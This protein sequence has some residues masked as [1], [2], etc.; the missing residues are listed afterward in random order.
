MIENKKYLFARDKKGY[1]ADNA[2]KIVFLLVVCL[3]FSFTG[4]EN[5]TIFEKIYLHLDRHYYLS[6]D[7]VWF[8]AYLVDAQT[9]KLSSKSSRIL[10]AEL[11][12]PESK[13]LMRR[14][15]FVDTDGC[16]I[17]DFK[18]KDN[19]I[20]GKYR[21]RAYTKWMLNFGDVFVFEKE[22]EVQNISEESTSTSK[23]EIKKKQKDN[24]NEKTITREDVEIEFFPESGSL[25]SEIANIV[26]F[27]ATDWSGKG[28]EVSGG[29]LNSNGDTVVLFASEYLGMGKF[30]FVPQ[31]GETYQAF[32]APKGVQYSQ[33]AKLPETLNKGFVMNISDVDTVF[34]LNIRTNQ[35]IF[36]EFSGK[37]MFLTFRQSEK[38]LFGHEIALNTR[39]K[40]VS[41]SKSLL[42]S[43]ITR[44]TLY[45]EHEKPHCERLVYIENKEKVNI[46][47]TPKDDT[48]SIIKVTDGNGQSVK[49][50]LSMSITNSIVPD[51]TFDIE[52]YLRLESEIKGKIER[53]TAY[54]DSANIDR[55]RQIDLL[56]LT[57]GWRDFVWK[58][59]ENNIPEFVGYEMEQGLKITGHVE[60]LVGSKPYPDATVALL[61]PDSDA[62]ISTYIPNLVQKKGR[63]FTR[64]DSLGNYG[65]GYMNFLGYRTLLLT[66]RTEKD[67]AAGEISINPLFMPAEE[68]PVKI[69]KQYQIDSTYRFVA[70]NY[71]KKDYKLTDTIVLDPVTI[72]DRKDGHLI[73]DREITP[74][75]DSLWMSLDFYI[76][77]QAS[78]LVTSHVESQILNS[79]KITFYDS[80][81]KRIR[82]KVPHPSKIS[83]KEVDRVRIY[84]KNTFVN[85]SEVPIAPNIKSA[86][87]F[88]RSIY[89]IDVYSKHDGFTEQNYATTR[90]KQEISE[91]SR[92]VSAKSAAGYYEEI[93]SI[94]FDYYQS[95]MPPI[96]EGSAK[97]LYRTTVG[98]VD[99]SSISP[100]VGGYY[101]ERKF[102]APKFY[103]TN[104]VKDYF[105]TYFWLADIR[106]DANGESLINYNPEKQP[107]G[108]IRIEGITNKG[109]PFAVKL[110]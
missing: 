99:F 81:G 100:I 67:K 13:L 55:F 47:I 104:E 34:I 25:I 16:A 21:I 56:L 37:T 2:K 82:S 36:G 10:Y 59:L 74:R 9:G 42:P 77:G 44:I 53:A 110:K 62:D 105:G 30:G 15:L 3:S 4:N 39:S 1:A 69:R 49:A 31:T 45:D 17:G 20:S 57:Q 52:S 8:K 87:H 61:F 48:T 12:S 58:H 66:S 90:Y 46:S 68:F 97:G 92:N 109:I 83:M 23:S 7:D 5:T 101:E 76:K 54:F 73:S 11:I 27:K 28:A 24:P 18:L 43:G 40:P 88:S 41:L 35:E 98:D 86:I 102:Y 89:S 85:A 71:T 32:F 38:L 64:T 60:K 93:T 63:R 72:S 95:V 94:N 108:K 19:A 33:Y 29:V 78:A 22:I 91:G 107:S 50:N 80:N 84:R 65:F 103:S 79:L 106:T 51:G 14:V 75:D 70:E 96:Y 6:G 26:A